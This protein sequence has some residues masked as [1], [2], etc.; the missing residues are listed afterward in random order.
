M[1]NKNTNT[2][3][4]IYGA[5]LSKDGKRIIITLVGGSEDKKEYYSTCIKLDGSQKSKVK[6][7]NDNSHVLVKVPMLKTRKEE[8]FE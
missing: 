6:V 8:D 5:K 2:L 4:S 3:L 7:A 1:E